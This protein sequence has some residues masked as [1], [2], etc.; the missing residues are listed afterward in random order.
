MIKQPV[1]LIDET[2]PR[3]TAPGQ[4]R[5]EKNGNKMVLRIL[6]SSRTGASHLD[7]LVSLVEFDFE[8]GSKKDIFQGKVISLNLEG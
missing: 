4:S 7:D 5:P 8:P 3:T 6:Q 1:W 2:L